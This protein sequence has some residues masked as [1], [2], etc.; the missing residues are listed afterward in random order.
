MPWC[1]RRRSTPSPGGAPTCPRCLPSG[2]AVMTSDRIEAADA[3]PL[4]S[5]PCSR[6]VWP[7]RRITSSSPSTRPASPTLTP[8]GARRSWR[9]PHGPRRGRWTS[10]GAAVPQ[11]PGVRR[12]MAGRGTHRSRQ[13][14]TEYLLDRGR[15][16]LLRGSDVSFL[17][18]A[19]R[20]RSQDYVA[21]LSAAITVL[22]LSDRLRCGRRRCRPCATSSSPLPVRGWMPGGPLT[23]FF[24][25]RS[26]EKA[27]A[28]AGAAVTPADPLVIV[29]TSGSTSEPKGVIH[30]HGA[31]IR[32]PRQSQPAPPVQRPRGPVLELALLLDRRLR[33]R[34]G[35]VV[36]G[37]TLV[38]SNAPTPADVLD[39]LERKRPTM[40]NGFRPVGGPRGAGPHVSRTR[41]LL[42]TARQPLPDHARQTS[43]RRSRRFTTPCWG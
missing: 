37:A 40:V 17:L 27:V 32:T 13:R 43:G 14:A 21:S 4:S 20:Y 28:A 23:V 6:P 36:A 7:A 10:G 18:A 41:P 19:P 30:T 9:R 16:G 15:A 35:T 34:L 5:P 1:A 38:C 31:L 29:H 2:D 25:M 22:D 11:R 24:V 42:H 3:L 12:R 39:V 33:L 8:I 26:A